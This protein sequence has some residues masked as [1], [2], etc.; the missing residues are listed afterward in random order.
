[1]TQVAEVT[2]GSSTGQSNFGKFVSVGF[3]SE[4]LEI[5]GSQYPWRWKET[6]KGWPW[7]SGVSVAKAARLVATG[8]LQET[9]ASLKPFILTPGISA[10]CL[11][12][13]TFCT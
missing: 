7:L 2:G 1:M 11:Q 13:S 3:S 8:S 10:C 4:D 12:R 5:W 6:R 9:A